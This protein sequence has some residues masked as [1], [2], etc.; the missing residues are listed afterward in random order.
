[1]ILRGS[2]VGN[3]SCQTSAKERQLFSHSFSISILTFPLALQSSCKSFFQKALFSLKL[4][5][6]HFLFGNFHE[7]LQNFG[8]RPGFHIEIRN[9]I[10][11]FKVLHWHSKI[12]RKYK[13]RKR[14]SLRKSIRKYKKKFWL[15]FTPCLQNLVLLFLY[16]SLFSPETWVS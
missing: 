15:N 10:L 2:V 3:V 1:M 13:K 8:K 11:I 4:K 14:K 7:I 16:S 5:A 9:F 6:L 12:L